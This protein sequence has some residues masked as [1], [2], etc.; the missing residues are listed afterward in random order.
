MDLIQ[1]PSPEKK[2]KEVSLI[3]TLFKKTVEYL[4]K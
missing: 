2:T 4:K 3:K 1:A